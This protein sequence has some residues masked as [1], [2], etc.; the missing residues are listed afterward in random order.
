MD[1]LAENLTGGVTYHYKV[2]RITK[3]TPGDYSN[4]VDVA[5]EAGTTETEAGTGVSPSRR[6]LS[7]ADGVHGH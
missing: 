3:G 7:R 5:Y 4:E 1:E 6:R 2:R